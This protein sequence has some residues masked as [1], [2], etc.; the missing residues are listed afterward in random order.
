[1]VS[2]VCS[3]LKIQ[4]DAIAEA[5]IKDTK[6]NLLITVKQILISEMFSSNP[7]YM[8]CV[9]GTRLGFVIA[10]VT[11]LA[12]VLRSKSQSKLSK[13]KKGNILAVTNSFS[14]ISIEW[15]NRKTLC[16]IHN[17]T[18]KCRTCPKTRENA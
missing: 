2:K 14:Y 10:G 17:F 1:V 16:E 6:L 13:R 8:R 3:A 12:D 7:N 15:V 18:N 5:T 11:H 9:V 4:N